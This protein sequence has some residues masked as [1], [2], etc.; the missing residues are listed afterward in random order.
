MASSK[1]YRRSISGGAISGL[2]EVKESVSDLSGESEDSEPDFTAID[3]SI[4]LWKGRLSFRIYLP[5]KPSKFGIKTFNLCESS[6]GYLLKFVVYSG[7][8]TDLQTSI[9]CGEN[10]KTSSIVVKLMEDLLNKGHTSWMDNYYNS[11]D[12]AAFLKKQGTNVAVTLR[13]NRTNVPTTVKCAKLKKGETIAQQS[14]GIMVMKWKDK[15]DVTINSTFHDASVMTEQEGGVEIKK[16]VCVT[17]YIKAFGGVGGSKRSEI[18]NISS[19][20]EAHQNNTMDHLTFR[21]Q[22]ITSLIER[23]GRAVHSR[24]QGRPSINPSPAVSL[25]D[26]SLKKYCQQEGRQ[27]HKKDVF[28]VRRIGK[29]GKQFIGTQTVKQ[30]CV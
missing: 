22:L 30:D 3:E 9:D 8:E 21:M 13:L 24:K 12:L 20:E 1:Y 4:T 25:K 14:D 15:E 26:I 10:N 5:L 18:T 27:S 6:T 23:Y 19:G 2:L 7:S 29:G 17:E 11:P 16:P 28:C